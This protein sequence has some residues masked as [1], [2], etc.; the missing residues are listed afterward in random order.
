M[1]CDKPITKPC[2]VLT[3]AVCLLWAVSSGAMAL[4][5]IG[6]SVGGDVGYYSIS[7]DPTG[8]D[9]SFDGQYQGTSP[10]TVEVH[11]SGTPGHTVS[12]SK[13][14][15]QTWME[16]L[17][18][19]PAPGETVQV[20]A[21]LIPIPV[22]ITVT[23]VGGD[24]GWYSVTSDPSGS[25]V[26]MDGSY[27]GETPVT[28][29]VY[30]TGTPG[31]TFRVSHPGYN[32]WTQT[33]ST[34]PPA[35]QTVNVFASL[36]PVQ[37]T[38]SI[39]VTSS[40]SGAL[41]TLDGTNQQSTPTAYPNVPTGYHTVQVSLAGYQPYTQRVQ[42]TN[43]AT[44]NVNAY[45]TPYQYSGSLRATSSPSGADLSIDGTYRGDTPVTIGNLATGSHQVSLRLAGYQPWTGTVSITSGATTT[46]SPTLVANPSS[47]TGW[48]LVSSNPSGASIYLDGS[49]QGQTVAG[50]D[51][52]IFDVSAGSHSIL[53]HLGG[54][55]DYSTSVSV[56]S[57]QSVTVS[58]TLNPSTQP[59]GGGTIE[60]VSTPGGADVYIDNQYRGITPLTLQNVPAGAHTLTF[61]AS[62]YSDYNAPVQV[63]DGQSIQV[64]AALSPISTP[65]PTK[66]G[67]LPFACIGA[68][69][70]I[71]LLLVMRRK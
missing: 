30:T 14:G 2:I 6:E 5:P 1:K 66:S 60:C 46:I 64:T 12:A 43:G 63:A 31:H 36:T 62:G 10:V 47:N 23:N 50:S 22:T 3:F 7:S 20:F 51:Y 26:Y 35:G 15:Y 45:L 37:S 19:N 52:D 57:G 11:V 29:Q 70:C 9:I 71:G 54:Y 44:S 48:I 21:T 56:A 32:D 42:V 34:N 18:G 38:G 41:A 39:Y 8:A 40:P 25:D 53:L 16:T 58:A 61:K 24:V 33:F 13:Q 68:L 27:W 17:P 4:Q 28:I 59:G 55:Q 69:G 65:T 49:Y 67:V